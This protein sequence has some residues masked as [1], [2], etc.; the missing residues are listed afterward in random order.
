MKRLIFIFAIAFMLICNTNIKSQTQDL[1]E[2]T[3]K[4]M[5]ETAEWFC[6]RFGDLGNFDKEC[7]LIG[8]L[9]DDNNGHYQT[10]TANKSIDEI[11]NKVK[12]L[13]RKDFKFVPDTMRRHRITTYGDDE[14]RALFIT[15]LYKND[16]PDLR[17]RKV[18]STYP[19]M[20][21]Y[22]NEIKTPDGSRDSVCNNP[23]NYDVELLSLSLAKTVAG[24]YNFD[25][26]NISAISSGGDIGYRGVI[27][28]EKITTNAQ[29]MSFLGGVLLRYGCSRWPDGSYSINIPLF[30]TA[31]EVADILKEFDCNNVKEIQTEYNTEYSEEFINFNASSKITDLIMLVNNLFNKIAGMLIVKCNCK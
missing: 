31:K 1:A 22:G 19:F 23:K 17:A 2:Q 8:T 27:N 5:L 15:T 13:F 26:D 16:Y 21:H 25:Y 28:K 12:W 10:F 11:D 9:L 24:Y 6:D 30:N 4:K 20:R 14:L 18:C 3:Q 29:K 7:F